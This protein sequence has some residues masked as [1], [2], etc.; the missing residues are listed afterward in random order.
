MEST[1]KKT[2]YVGRK[3]AC[4]ESKVRYISID[5][6][7]CFGM[8]VALMKVIFIQLKRRV[9]TIDGYADVPSNNETELLR[10]VAAQPVSAGVCG[11]ERA[12]R[13]C[14]SG[15]LSGP[16][17]ITLDPAVLI[18]DYGSENGVDYWIIKNSWGT[19]WGMKGYMLTP[20]ILTGLVVSTG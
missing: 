11:I 6:L 16:C 3:S 1:Q 9:V 7:T 12:F 19:S 18:V 5:P 13:F 17:S 2:T 15:I 14:S 4:I 10:A 8:A 20:D